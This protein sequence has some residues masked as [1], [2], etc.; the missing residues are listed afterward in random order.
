MIEDTS[1][2]MSDEGALLSSLAGGTAAE[3]APFLKHPNV[4]VRVKL[5][6]DPQPTY[7]G[8]IHA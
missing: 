7:E 3:L 4:Y 2:D 1:N 6:R 5:A 8:K